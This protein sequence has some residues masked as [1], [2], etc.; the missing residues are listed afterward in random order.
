MNRSTILNAATWPRRKLA[1]E[2]RNFDSPCYSLTVKLKAEALFRHA[3][4]HGESFFLL[5]LYA[6]LR[7]TTAVPQIRQRWQ[8]DAV[9]EFET[10]SIMTP[11]MGAEDMFHEAW[12]D[13]APDF[14]SFK[15]SASPRIEAAKAG[16]G[17]CLTEERQDFICANCIPWLHFE[18]MSSAHY[19]FQQSVPILTWGKL[20]DGKI[21]VAVKLNH[22][23]MDGLHAGRFF[24]ALADGFAHPER[25]YTRV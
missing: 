16:N 14:L 18:S 21:P 2:Y 12:C 11:V 13:S 9:I 15:A 3:K 25:L 23:F 7:A 6:I 17:C 19:D 8:G 22:C 4:A 10:L 24:D 20:E 5:A 1:E